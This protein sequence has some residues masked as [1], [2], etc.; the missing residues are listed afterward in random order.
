MSPIRPASLIQVV[1]SAY[2]PPAEAPN[3]TLRESDVIEPP[4]PSVNAQA[5]APTGGSS[6]GASPKPSGQPRIAACFFLSYLAMAIAALF[7][8]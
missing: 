2:L 1:T 7:V 5:P 8:F 4:L 3:P 6:V